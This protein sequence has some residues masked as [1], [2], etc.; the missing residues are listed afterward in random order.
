MVLDLMTLT[1]KSVIQEPPSAMA[2]S[3][4]FLINIASVADE[5]PLWGHSQVVRDQLL[6]RFWPT[7]PIFASSLGS[8][9]MRYAAFGWTVEGG[10]RTARYVRQILH[11]VERGE[12]WIPF[13]QKVLTD[14]FTQDN[15]AFIEIV[16]ATPNDPL[17][18]VVSLNHLDA[19]RCV[20]TGL[21]DTP[22]Y[23]RDLMGKLHA[24]KYYEVITLEEMPCPI[25][26]YHSQQYCCL[27]RMLR[28][29][30]I[31]RDI[32]VYKQEKLSGRYH[33]SIHLVSGVQTPTIESALRQQQTIYDDRGN[34]RY[35]QPAIIA[36]LDPTAHVTHAQ[37]D[38]ASLPDGFD[39][40][41]FAKWYIN[42]IALGFGGDYQDYAPLPGGNLGTSQQSEIL[43]L[44]SR[45]KGPALFMRLLEQ[46]FNM[47]GVMP[48]NVT[49]S[50]GEQ[51]AT[52]NLELAKLRMIRAQT[53]TMLC[54][55]DA[56]ILTPAMA[57]QM[58]LD[59]GDI[60]EEYLKLI[61]EGN[62]TQDE[63]LQA[64]M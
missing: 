2:T 1:Q 25:E 49:F 12:G 18:P 62:A 26:D 56:P 24:M 27:T 19:A 29:V 61:G 7:E 5:F 39:E 21:T 14:L 45:G 15:G 48:S 63:I 50:F 17:S 34:I 44:K 43:H 22:V 51:D 52:A 47:H 4:S 16:R 23:Y 60:T 57:R 64:S 9:I 35:I 55:G 13:I 6:R 53:L 8:T 33:R 59:D 31:A 11:S 37:I 32:A 20:R 58:M 36:S 10:P 28:A 42:Q 46:R 41:I 3:G 30:Q 40:E 38:L 54:S